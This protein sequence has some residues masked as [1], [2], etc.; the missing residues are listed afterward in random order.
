V[1]LRVAPDP[2][3]GAHV[4][5]ALALGELAAP[6]ERARLPAPEAGDAA[7]LSEGGEAGEAGASADRHATPQTG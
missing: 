5:R 6:P 1:R 7:A 4:Q 3:L 2:R